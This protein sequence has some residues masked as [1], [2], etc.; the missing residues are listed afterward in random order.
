MQYIENTQIHLIKYSMISFTFSLLY[1]LGINLIPG[2]FRIPSLN[3][4]K[5]DKECMYKISKIIQ[6]I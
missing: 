5:D 1:P 3:S 2:I 4:P 6:L